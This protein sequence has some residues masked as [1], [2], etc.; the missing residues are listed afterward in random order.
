MWSQLVPHRGRT[1]SKRRS[2]TTYVGSFCDG[3]KYLEDFHIRAQ[4]SSRF[5]PLVR[6]HRNARSTGMTASRDSNAVAGGL[7][8]HI[9]VLLSE[10]IEALNV[11]AGG[12]YIDGTFGA[13]GYSRAILEKPETRV[14]GIDRDQD[15]I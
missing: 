2:G 14:I 6:A 1:S 7:A 11:R 3:G 10:S 5:A 4:Q 15:A 12:V 8:R 13:G 9:P